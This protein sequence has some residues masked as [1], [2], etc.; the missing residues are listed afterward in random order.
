MDI[1]LQKFLLRVL[2]ALG[3]V[4]ATTDYLYQQAHGQSWP[5]LSKP[6]LEAHLLVLANHRFVISYEPPMQAKR[7]KITP[8]GEVQLRVLGFA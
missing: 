3:T 6:D 4:G 7:W 2:G 8:D 1:E 5:Q